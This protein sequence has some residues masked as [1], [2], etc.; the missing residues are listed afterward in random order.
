MY[1]YWDIMIRIFPI[2]SQIIHWKYWGIY[3]KWLTQDKLPINMD[4]VFFVCISLESRCS[5]FELWNYRFF[6]WKH[7]KC[8]W[9]NPDINFLSTNQA[10]KCREHSFMSSIESLL[11]I[12]IHNG[13]YI[14]L[15]SCS[16]IQLWRW[17]CF[18][19]SELHKKHHACPQPTGS[20][21]TIA[22]GKNIKCLMYTY[23]KIF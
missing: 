14:W 4:Q 9:R 5:L 10:T 8:N 23:F 21:V 6:Y 2:Y 22:A 16:F 11:R 20:Q 15:Y 17:C 12:I 18:N 3:N 19:I 13:F 1:A 7:T